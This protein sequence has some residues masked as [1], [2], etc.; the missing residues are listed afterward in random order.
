MEEL[1]AKRYVKAIV[2]SFNAKSM[3]NVATIFSTLANAFQDENFKNLMN[4]PDVSLSEKSDI[5]LASVKSV[6]SAEL[7]NIIKLIVDNKRINIIPAIAEE[8]RKHLA[9]TT[10]SYN[11]I[12][13][14][15]S[16]IDTGMIRKL[17]NGL[18]KKL[19]S[20][21]ALTF[22]KNDYDGIKV[23]VEDLGVEID[24]SQARISNQMI[25]HIIKAI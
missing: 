24:F 22:V 20:K 6:K 4:N 3:K 13:Y 17:S 23:N 10:K 5:L 21:I 2:S 25:E 9:E 14:S 16:K 12:I 11:G 7:N 15:D 19:D 18:S 8:I 1:I